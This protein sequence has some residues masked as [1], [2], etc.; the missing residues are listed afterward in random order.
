MVPW[1]VTRLRPQLR[2]A[3]LPL[4]CAVVTASADDAAA[5]CR[6][7]TCKGASCGVDAQ[8]CPASGAKLWWRTAC[9]GYSLQRNGTQ[10][11]PMDKV[12]EA[13]RGAFQAWSDVD[14]GSGKSASMTFGERPDTGCITSEFNSGGPNVNVLI[15]RDN[16]WAY[17]NADNTLA[18]AI[19]HYDGKT[20]EILDAD[21]EVNTASN[22]FTLTNKNAQFDLQTVLTHEV[23]HFLG[24]SHSS[25]PSA[26]MYA[27]YERGSV[28]G[29]K[30]APDDIAA[31]CTAYPPERI[32]SC[33]L[34]PSGGFDT[35][36]KAAPTSM[37]GAARPDA[38][39]SG[40]LPM[41]LMLL[42]LV[43]YRARAKDFR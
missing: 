27:S 16:D 21:I 32:A 38:S 23:G 39:G 14:C 19:A 6:S 36:A 37:C 42:V 4:V 20:G 1:T 18:K 26:V 28:Q 10:N 5:F 9:V 40:W 3:L 11:L 8:D 41:L 30:L 43:G 2:V 7:T 17:K 34:T 12:K 15:F 33:D 35:C 25:D 29:R 31:L 24:L 22:H 13:V